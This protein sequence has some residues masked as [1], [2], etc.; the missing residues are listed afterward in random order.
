[1]SLIQTLF[2]RLQADV[3]SYISDMKKAGATTTDT[4]TSLKGMATQALGMIGGVA[5]LGTAVHAMAQYMGEAEKAA[6]ESNLVQAKQEAILK[7][8]GYAAGLTASQLGAMAQE[9]SK[10][11][12]IDDEAIGSA[13]SLMLTFRNIGSEAFPR[14]I[15][16]ALDMQTT[17]GGLESASM[18]LGKALN[19]PVAGITAL[20]RAGVTFSAAQKTQIQNF[21]AVNDIASAQAMILSEVEHQVGGTAAAMADASDGSDRMKVSADNLSEAIGQE[22]VPTMRDW[23]NLLGGIYDNLT[24]DIT[25][26]DR[27]A[28]ALIIVTKQHGMNADQM[29]RARASRKDYNLEIEKEIADQQGYARMSQTATQAVKAQVQGLEIEAEWLSNNRDLFL[30]EA[31]AK[32][33]SAAASGKMEDAATKLAN[34]IYT[35]QATQRALTED[36]WAGKVS[37]DAYTAQMNSLNAELK[38]LQAP[39][40]I[41][42]GVDTAQATANVQTLIDILQKY[43]DDFMDFMTGGPEGITPGHGTTNPSET[44]QTGAGVVNIETLSGRPR[45]VVPAS[46]D[47]SKRATGGGAGGLTMVGEEGA[48]LVDLPEG[49][50]VYS[51]PQSKAII[52]NLPHM[53]EGSSM[54]ERMTAEEPLWHPHSGVAEP[55]RSDVSG[56]GGASRNT[57][58]KVTA[59]EETVSNNQKQVASSN[60]ALQNTIQDLTK[61]LHNMRTIEIDYSKLTRCIRD[62]FLKAGV[63]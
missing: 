56:G 24:N 37:G 5:A 47:Y 1:M 19:D 59:L 55:R 58:R 21:M 3:N 48:E 2:V 38:D 50:H 13:Q 32:M 10:L 62:G 53:S 29:A 46:P 27:Y 43:K 63:R 34:K 11:T 9:Q 35:L 45:Y 8:T 15:S 42:I 41:T 51:N 49:S 40:P 54:W 14:A 7:A 36:W 33:G 28:N 17:F 23:N 22:L 18:M 20:A 16:A 61:E 31:S 25:E 30:R 12:G 57:E 44:R 60:Q 26:M 4:G 6:N 52:D 39:E